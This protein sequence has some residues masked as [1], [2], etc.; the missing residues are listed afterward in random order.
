MATAS[1]KGI[2]VTAIPPA[3]TAAAAT[4]Q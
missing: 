2:G 4:I 3:L 1:E